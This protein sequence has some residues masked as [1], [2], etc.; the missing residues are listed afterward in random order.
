MKISPV[1]FKSGIIKIGY[2]RINP[3]TIKTYEPDIYGFR[4]NVNFLDG[5]KK[6][7]KIR[8]DIFE[9]AMLD[10]KNSNEIIDI[11]DKEGKVFG[12]E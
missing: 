5:E 8:F 6:Y 11:S 1:S 2:Q 10:A 7:L 4:T 9:K 12:D 3:D